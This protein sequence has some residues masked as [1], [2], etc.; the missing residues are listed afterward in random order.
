MK[1]VINPLEKSFDISFEGWTYTI[2]VDGKGVLVR[3]DRVA[4]FFEEKCPFLRVRKPPKT[5]GV[6]PYPQITRKKTPIYIK[7]SPYAEDLGTEDMKISKVGVND[8]T[9][10]I[11]NL[12]K[13]GTV[14]RDGVEWVGEG[15]EIDE[16]V[17]KRG[18]F[19]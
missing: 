6:S 19:Y 17:T 15:I 7:S 9:M 1:L 8:A 2:P 5:K 10:N 3:E 4:A 16:D 18:T 12:P 11:D 13:S 14:D